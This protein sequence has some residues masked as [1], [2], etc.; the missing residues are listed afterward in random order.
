MTSQPLP[1][2]ASAPRPG[3]SQRRRAPATTPPPPSTHH[4]TNRPNIHQHVSYLSPTQTDSPYPPLPA[5]LSLLPRTTQHDAPAFLPIL[6]APAY[7]PL[8]AWHHV[9]DDLIRHPE[10]NSSNILRA[11]ILEQQTCDSTSSND[12]DIDGYRPIK[13]IR[14]SI[15]PRRPGLDWE[16]HQECT[17]YHR[18][19]PLDASSIREAVVVYTPIASPQA[20]QRFSEGWIDDPTRRLSF[21]SHEEQIPFYHP[22]VRAIA[23]R[24]FVSQPQPQSQHDGAEAAASSHDDDA[25]RS[26]PIFGTHSIALVP[27]GPDQSAALPPTHRLARISLHLVTTLHTHTWGRTH[28]YVKRV[29]HDVVVPREAFQDLYLQLKAR[30]ASHLIATWAERTDPSKHVFEDLGIAAF[31]ILLWR[32]WWGDATTG[33]PGGFVDVGC[34]NGLLV[35]ILNQEGFQGHGFDLRA[36][37]S[38]ATY[39]D[40][41]DLREHKFH[42][43]RFVARRLERAGEGEDEGK[44]EPA[45]TAEAVNGDEGDG[46]DDDDEAVAN[47]F[48]PHCFLIGNH[49]DEL[50]PWLPLLS[51]SLGL[52][53]GCSGFINIPCC[54]FM[55][56]GDKFTSMRY[57]PIERDDIVPLL[58]PHHPSSSSL[59]EEEEKRVEET[60]TAMQR[61]PTSTE[62]G[63]SRNGAYLS[64]LSH[65][66][67]NLGWTMEKEALRIPSTKNWCIVGRNLFLDSVDDVEHRRRMRTELRKRC[68]DAVSATT[69]SWSPRVGI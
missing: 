24:Y 13:R 28:N 48:P 59:S 11:D 32:K 12:A 49:A 9:M 10:R 45:S 17:L 64:Y 14:R 27:F 20:R 37:R 40:G 66:H 41:A 21:P 57:I 25:E 55:L 36:R 3:P 7:A 30:H 51:T 31:L 39:G 16:M 8:D 15:L 26:L 62:G 22:K 2:T 53:T 46:D 5:S 52:T 34:G 65:L 56:G 4:A 1:S 19:D 23:F 63:E 33:P 47:L 43:P 68:I 35:W 18:T 69:T 6:A 50:T 54:P 58:F 29:H 61:G 60:V 44:T 38:W 67:V 42:V